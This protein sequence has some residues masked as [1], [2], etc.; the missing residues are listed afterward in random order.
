MPLDFVRLSQSHTGEYL[1]NTVQLVVKKFGIQEKICGVVSDNAKNN[2]V[3][4]NKL[5]KLKW[6]RFKG[7]AQWIRCFAHVLNLIV[8]AIL[9]PFGT[10]KKKKGATNG[11]GS[12]SDPSESDDDEGTE[13]QI[14]TLPRGQN[15][16]LPEYYLS[17]AD[18]HSISDDDEAESLSEADIEQASNEDEDNCYT[19]ETCKQTL[20]K[21]QM[22]AKKL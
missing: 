14:R 10:Q 22:I 17:D 6:S 4:V 7:D 2:E 15:F 3:M 11:P 20:A 12:I 5:K 8:Q 19:T 9:R 13:G 21:F 1:A 18:S 16:S